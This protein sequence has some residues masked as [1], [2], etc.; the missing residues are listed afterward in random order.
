[1]TPRR[2]QDNTNPG[3]WEKF[4]G[5]GQAIDTNKYFV[6]CTNVLGGCFGSTCVYKGFTSLLSPPCPLTVLSPFFSF[7]TNLLTSR[8]PSSLNPFTNEVCW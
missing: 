4:I 6:I 3:W 7:R 1:M 2:L 5:P 8:G